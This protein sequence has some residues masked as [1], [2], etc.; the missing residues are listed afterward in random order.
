MSKIVIGIPVIDAHEMTGQTLSTTAS[1]VSSPDD[2]T[3][4]IID[5]NSKKPYKKIEGF[6]FKIDV[7]RNDVNR[8]YYYPLL[9]LHDAYPDADYIGLMHNDAVIFE[10][11]WDNKVRKAF[12]EDD[13]LKMLGLFGWQ[14]VTRSGK[15]EDPVG[16]IYWP[17]SVDDPE[18]PPEWSQ[19]HRRV[20]TVTPAVSL[21]SLFMIFPHEIIP[22]LGI[23]EDITISHG[24]DKIWS[25]RLTQRGYHVA[26]AGIPFQHKGGNDKDPEFNQ[27]FKE[28][29]DKRWDVNCPLDWVYHIAFFETQV[30][31]VME[32]RE[33]TPM[34]PVHIND[35]YSLS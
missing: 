26:V 1:Y 34:L 35:N 6:P 12:E 25:L 18:H 16:K 2:I 8:G 15:N 11:G 29:F 5:N 9:Q 10:E 32:F 22:S 23:N 21:D 17:F 13:K 19:Y 14:T 7:L 33:N 27:Y 31:V 4:V 30:R 24:Y 3:F 20:H 28:W